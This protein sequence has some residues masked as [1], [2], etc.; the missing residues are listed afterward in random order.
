[1]YQQASQVVLEVKNP[2]ASTE[3]PRDIGW[4]DPTEKDMAAHSSILA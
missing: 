4:E 3:D 2:P 1:M